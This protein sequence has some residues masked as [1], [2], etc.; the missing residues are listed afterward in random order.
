MDLLT[1]KDLSFKYPKTETPALEGVSFSLKRGGF[2]LLCG[3]TGCGK[4]TLLRLLKPE[5]APFGTLAGTVGFAPDMG[6]APAPNE[7]GLVTQD[8]NEQIVTDKVWHELAFGLENMGL[9]QEEIRIRTGETASYFGLAE[10]FGAA[11]ESLSGGEKQLLSLAAAVITS[12]KL[13]LLD[14]PTSQLDPITAMNF[15]DTLKRVNRDFGITVFLAEHR[16]EE[17]FSLADTV[18]AMDAGKLIACAPPAEV[19]RTLKDSRL[20][21]GFP[22]AARLWKALDSDAPCPVNVREGKTLLQTALKNEPKPFTPPQPVK[23]EAPE[24]L[25]AKGLWFRY[26]KDGADVLKDLSLTLRQGEVFSIL[27]ANGVGKTTLLQTLC[28][29]RRPYHGRVK[30]YG[31][32]IKDFKRG[33]LYKNGISL[34]PQDP[35]TVF[36]KD[37]VRED[38]EEILHAGG[39]KKEAAAEAA[40]TAADAY[41]VTPLLDKNPLDLS[42]GERQKC[43]I[44]KM[45][46]TEPR[47]LLLDEPTKG[48]DAYSKQR[49]AQLLRKLADE[50][51]TVLAVT[52]DIEFAAVI[53]DTCALLFDGVLLAAG[54]PHAFFTGNTFYTTAAARM[55]SGLVPG[56]IFVEEIARCAR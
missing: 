15:L 41:G 2:Y 18:L 17:V 6:D 1:V 50:G 14:E 31:K 26:T 21:M 52:H 29:V 22:S 24:A 55:A 34:L 23:T 32:D 54:A 42:G 49:L 4:T 19:C 27:G 38:L 16:L 30:L 5:L 20:F 3:Y 48:L 53:S 43:A 10:K 28:G 47:V 39:Q 46:L 37:T 33:S 7:I 56:A 40:A 8:P 35:K 12:P 13:L 51:K 25:S 36:I 11:T 44:V 9:G 45:L